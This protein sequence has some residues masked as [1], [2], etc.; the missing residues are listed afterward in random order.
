MRRLVVLAAALALLAAGCG[1]KSYSSKLN[2]ICQDLTT[3]QASLGLPT[4]LTDL[5]GEGPALLAAF[6]GSI[7]K[8]RALDPPAKLRDAA[9]RY[10]ALK[11]E[12]RAQLAELIRLA[13][14]NDTKGIG[15]LGA[16][17]EPLNTKANAI[18]NDELH[19]PACGQNGGIS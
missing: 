18:A 13:A 4:S 12:Q 14:K 11:E 7:A 8:T 17:I 1:G 9:R 15:K 2:T 5:A 3:K 16:E 10:V 6:D 19:A